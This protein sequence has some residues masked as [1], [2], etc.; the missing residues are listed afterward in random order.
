MELTNINNDYIDLLIS[1]SRGNSN[2]SKLS[3]N[4]RKSLAEMIDYLTKLTKEG[5]IDSNQFSELILLA[6]GNYIENEIDWRLNKFI[7]SKFI[8]YFN[9]IM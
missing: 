6:C 7:N 5:K 9:K 1:N 8:Y 2:I 4:N 3:E